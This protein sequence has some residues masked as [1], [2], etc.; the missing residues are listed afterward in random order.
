MV[1]GVIYAKLLQRVELKPQL[2]NDIVNAIDLREREQ[3]GEIT[4]TLRQISATTSAARTTSRSSL[5]GAQ[6]STSNLYEPVRAQLRYALLKMGP[7][8]QLLDREHVTLY[9]PAAFVGET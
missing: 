4:S 8:H 5:T 1:S 9:R 2:H 3:A 6:W 7:R